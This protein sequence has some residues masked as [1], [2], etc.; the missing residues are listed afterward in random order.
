MQQVVYQVTRFCHLAN[1]HVSSVACQT[2]HAV[3]T[4]C[5]TPV[6]Q[7]CG[8]AH[9]SGVR[10][11][12]RCQEASVSGRWCE[13]SRVGALGLGV[14]EDAARGPSVSPSA[15]AR[16]RVLRGTRPRVCAHTLATPSSFPN[17]TEVPRETASLPSTGPGT[18]AF[19]GPPV[20]LLGS[21]L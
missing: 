9:R 16:P 12:K 14:G 1:R 6:T 18:Q 4:Q 10:G 2:Q 20:T 15:F 7:F 11:S 19:F 8:Q 21:R 3:E 5:W 13:K 17:R